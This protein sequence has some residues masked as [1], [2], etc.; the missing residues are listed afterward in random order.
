ML[1]GCVRSAIFSTQRIRCLLVVRH[2]SYV[3]VL[4]MLFL[5]MERIGP[6]SDWSGRQ[7]YAGARHST[8]DSAFRS[9]NQEF[10]A[11]AVRCSLASAVRSAA[12]ALISSSSISLGERRNSG[13][14]TWKV[15]PLFSALSTE[16]VPL[17]ALQMALT[18][19]SPSPVPPD[20]RERA[21]SVR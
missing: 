14:R 1:S 15:D 20:S 12:A 5:A 11:G 8:R 9:R 7:S 16:T 2:D 10:A 19:A 6:F 21:L 18:M 17:W 3:L 4:G 13:S